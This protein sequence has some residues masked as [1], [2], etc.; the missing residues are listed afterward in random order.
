MTKEFFEI[1]PI[2]PDDKIPMRVGLHMLSPE[3]IRQR[4]FA[5]KKD[6]TEEELKFLT[7]VDQVNHLAYVA[8]HH[9]DGQLLPAGVIRAIKDSERPTFA[10]IGITIVDCYQGHGLGTKLMDEI[11]KRALAVGFTHFYGDFHT[12]NQ[13]MSKLLDSFSKAH[14]PLHLKHKGDGFIYFEAPLKN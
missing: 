9:K 8:V 14:A 13:K 4:F 10:E 11:A 1:R 12:S 3:S 2:S 5:N 7:E 6:F